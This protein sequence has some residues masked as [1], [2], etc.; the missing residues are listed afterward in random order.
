MWGKGLGPS[1]RGKERKC[2]GLLP[3]YTQSF[4]IV[5][6]PFVIRVQIIYYWELVLQ[7][8]IK[9]ISVFLDRVRKETFFFDPI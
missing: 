9:N 6:R 5:N 2:S 4:V 1:V 8:P 3:I 7:F